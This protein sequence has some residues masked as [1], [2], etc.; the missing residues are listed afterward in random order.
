MLGVLMFGVKADMFFVGGRGGLKRFGMEG[1]GGCANEMT[2]LQSNFER[3]CF[4]IFFGT[5]VGLD[6][7]P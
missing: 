3:I 2:N 5:G 4:W 1:P 7:R 6:C